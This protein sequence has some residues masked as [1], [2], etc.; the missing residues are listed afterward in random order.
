MAT[1]VVAAGANL[2]VDVV[3]GPGEQKTAGGIVIPEARKSGQ[4]LFG[5][6][7]SVGPN[8]GKSEGNTSLPGDA[9]PETFK[10]GDVVVFERSA[11]V[12]LAGS[13]AT[14]ALVLAKDVL[15]RL[16]QDNAP[17]IVKPGEKAKH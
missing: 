3:G 14:I 15:A 11:G 1:R 17:V 16:E 8:V 9:E 13:L 2:A 10:V 4:V 7:F 5:R 6:V 12:E